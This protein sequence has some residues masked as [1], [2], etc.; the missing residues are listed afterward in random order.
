ME[1]LS[2]ILRPVVQPITHNLPDAL[3]DPLISL[4][5]PKCYH[6]L[7]HDVDLADSDCLRLGI[8]KALGLG[9]IG[10][11]AVVK[12]PQLLKIL[13]AQSGE[14]ISFLSYLLE[15]LAY[16][17]TLA[18][19]ARQGFPFST[20][21]ETALIA[22]QNVAISLLVLHYA[23]RDAAAAVFVA[24]L[25]AGVYALMTE[26]TVDM[27]L[28][29]YLQAGAGVLGVAS[30][31]PQVWTIWQEGGTGQLSAFAVFN[32]LFG[33]LSRIFTTLQEVDDR[34]ILYGFVAG[35]ALNAV[36]AGQM[37]Y[38]WNSPS[39]NKSS[40]PKL[41]VSDKEGGMKVTNSTGSSPSK[42]SKTPSTRRRG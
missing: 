10:A 20:Y 29:S 22:L 13:N 42:G 5:G 8:S 18:Y 12:I 3:R 15:T 14:G 40:G 26:S 23:G 30:K 21:G 11:S 39:S 24:G 38:Y 35:F 41:Q 16:T 1:A 31:L 33:S 28:L 7:L 37:L 4:L 34:L 6:I 36:L 19:N 17:I 32:Y 9:I 25:G 27:S 2:S